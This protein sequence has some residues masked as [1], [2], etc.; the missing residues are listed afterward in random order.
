MARFL[1]AAG[2]LIA[3]LTL[4]AG[5]AVMIGFATLL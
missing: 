1:E 3:T 5:G 4:I 2:D